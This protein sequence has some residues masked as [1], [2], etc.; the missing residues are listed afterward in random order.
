MKLVKVNGGAS[1]AVYKSR[2]RRKVAELLTNGRVN[3][4]ALADY[5]QGS[6]LEGI[7]HDLIRKIAMVDSLVRKTQ[8]QMQMQ[9]IAK[10]KNPS[11]A[12]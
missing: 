8:K 10:Y 5:S 9:D 11:S 12:D 2:Q 6:E 4:L 7:V 3:Y 1:L